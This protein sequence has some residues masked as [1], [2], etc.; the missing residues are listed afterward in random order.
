MPIWAVLYLAALAITSVVGLVVERREG[1]G[2]GYMTVDGIVTAIW[3]W[4]VIAYFHANLAEPVGLGTPALFAVA[5]AWTLWVGHAYVRRPD[6]D[7]DLSP[8]ENLVG[9]LIAIA[10]GVGLAAP[11]ITLG[12]LVAWRALPR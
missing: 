6:V 2:V 9:D 8:T 7:P 11:A 3:V 10:V 12:A 4:L 5:L 1:R